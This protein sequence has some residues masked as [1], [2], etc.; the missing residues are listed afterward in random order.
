MVLNTCFPIQE[1]ETY[2]IYPFDRAIIM[3]TI[4]NL[5]NKK[6]TPHKGGPYRDCI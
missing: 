4:L 5:A 2:I 3:P 1:L 6:K